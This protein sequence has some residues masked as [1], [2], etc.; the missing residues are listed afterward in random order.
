MTLSKHLV[1]KNFVCLVEAYFL[2]LLHGRKTLLLDQI[3]ELIHSNKCQLLFST[4]TKLRVTPYDDQKIPWGDRCSQT[5]TV[6]Q[7]VEPLSDKYHVALLVCII[8]A[9]AHRI[10][11][12]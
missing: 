9:Q 12:S 10:Q 11:L 7:E 6:S 1:F 3:F 4:S 5:M 2:Y 8:S